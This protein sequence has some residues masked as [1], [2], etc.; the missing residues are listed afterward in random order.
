MLRRLVEQQGL[1]LPQA[2][3]PVGNY[4]AAQ[5][6]G[7]LLYISGQLPLRDE[8]LIYQGKLGRDL[9]VEQGQQAAELCAL[10]L[11]SQ[12]DRYIAN[13]QLESVV[14]LE[15]YI[16]SSDSFVEH[17][18]VLNGASDLLFKVLGASAGHTR[19]VIG[20]TSLPLNAPVE[21]AAVVAL[22]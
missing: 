20:C 19:I 13:R 4:A 15:G 7:G 11:L 1:V 17:A 10:N 22:Q 12:L 14:K 2:P 5:L 21:I 6:A 18:K 9:S 8:E 3:T 16:N